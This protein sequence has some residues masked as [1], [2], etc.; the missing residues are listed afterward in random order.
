MPLLVHYVLQLFHFCILSFKSF[1]LVVYV[2]E[3]NSFGHFFNFSLE[4]LVLY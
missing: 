4:T 3:M 2:F 1:I